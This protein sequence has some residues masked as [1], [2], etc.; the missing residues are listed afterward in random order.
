[1]NGTNTL[2]GCTS[3]NS[4]VQTIT[5]NA[6]PTVTANATA[7]VVCFGG[8]VTLSGSGAN[9]YSWTGGVS[10]GVSFTPNSTTTYTLSGTS[11]A[12]CT[13]TNLAV[14][15]ITVN[16]LPVVA[17]PGGS[18][19]SGQSFTLT[20]T[21]AFTYTYSN[22]PVVS[23]SITTSYSVTGT[24]TNGCVTGTAAVVT[25]TVDTT[26]T[27]SVNSGTICF[28]QSFTIVPSGANSY[29]LQGSN[30]VVSPTITST[31]TIIGSSAAGCISANTET[32]SVF[33]NSLPNVV[34]KATDTVICYGK[35]VT[36]SGSGANTYSWTSGVI[37][38]ASFSPTTTATYSVTGTNANGCENFASVTV[39]VNSLPSLTISSSNTLACAGET[40]QL[41]GSGANTYTWSS[42]ETTSV[43]T[44]TLAAVSDIT[45]TGTDANG[46]ANTS[47]FT[48]SVTPC[49]GTFAV[50]PIVSNVSCRD[51]NDGRIDVTP[52][53]TFTNNKVNY[54]WSPSTLCPGNDCAQLENLK[55]GTYS[56]TVKVIYTV[57]S[58]FVKNDS[59]SIAMTIKDENPPC[60]LIVYTGVTPNNDGVNDVWKIENIE[61]YP[62]NHIQ[63]FNRWGSKV[64]DIKGYNNNTKSWPT[65]EEFKSLT[66]STYFYLI[67]LGDNSPPVKGWLEIMGN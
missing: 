2:T 40:I 30:T 6:L 64:M 36:L 25:I 26:P 45:L 61:L 4:A 57:T 59:T 42:S 41:S 13:N 31:Y 14:Q 46:C 32:S 21:G 5:V 28:G 19:C 22:G 66:P 20:P 55:A 54:Y 8:T 65:A 47:I 1:V 15:T 56:V 23:P 44:V 33:V 10:N 7:T 37:D 60:N 62:N 35:S 9:T 43:I 49:S 18:I 39:T 63:V 12:G 3:T 16:A 58:T 24:G 50:V 51:K 34:I 17:V 67:D 29:T 11:L 48:Q 38:N 27:V 53:L 52:I